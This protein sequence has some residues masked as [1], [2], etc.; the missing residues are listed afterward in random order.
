MRTDTGYMRRSVP[1]GAREIH[2]GTNIMYWTTCREC[3]AR[4]I[5]SAPGLVRLCPVCEA[6]KKWREWHLRM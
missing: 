1:E 2:V 6:R 4:F 5:T 3:G